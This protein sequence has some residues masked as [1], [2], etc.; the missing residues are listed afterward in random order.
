MFKIVFKVGEKTMAFLKKNYQKGVWL[1]ALSALMLVSACSESSKDEETASPEISKKATVFGVQVFATNGFSDTKMKHVINVLAE[2]LDNDGDGDV[3]DATIKTALVNQKAAMALYVNK[4][5]KEDVDD[6]NLDGLSVQNLF[7]FETRPEGSSAAGFDAT[8]EEVLHLITDYG[9]AKAYPAVFG[10][11]KGSS[12]ANAMDKARGGYFET[13]PSPYPSGSWY[14]Y[15]DSSCTYA[16]QI[17]EY[18]YWALTTKLGA[19]EGDD[20]Y[21]NIKDEWDIE[22]EANTV[23]LATI[24]PDVTS[25]LQTHQDSRT[26]P[27]T[28]PDGIYTAKTFV[29][30]TI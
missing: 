28:I 30:E 4:E 13:I 21:D 24:D 14:H 3:D 22:P 29:I 16:C 26:L 5:E 1:I 23:N 8:L 25:L 12:I 6:S 27:R 15:T 10:I 2:Y 18:L 17:T 19:Q 9:Y 7:A 11:V 20:R